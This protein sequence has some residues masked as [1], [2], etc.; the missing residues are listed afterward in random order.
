MQTINVK[1]TLPIAHLLE[2]IIGLK[3][4]HNGRQTGDTCIEPY[5]GREREVIV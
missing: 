1:V 3:L 5:A 2:R 4:A